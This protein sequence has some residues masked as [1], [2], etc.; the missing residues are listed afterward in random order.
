MTNQ[1]E[2]DCLSDPEDNTSVPTDNDGDNL[3]DEL[4]DDDD[5][6]GLTDLFEGSRNNRD[7]DGDGQTKLHFGY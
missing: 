6:D 1:V 2:L 7:S 4:D 3:C 5:N